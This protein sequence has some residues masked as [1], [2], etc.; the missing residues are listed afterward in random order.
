MNWIVPYSTTWTWL[1]QGS[2]NELP[3]KISA[4]A[5]S[6]G[7]EH[8]CAVVDDE[9]EVALAVGLPHGALGEREEL[10]AQVDERHSAHPAA[11][12]QLEEAP[13]ERQRLVERADLDGDVIDP[14][15]ASHCVA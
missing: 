3:P 14:D 10:V 4:P 12:L 6:G 7:R 9:P 11:E 15:R 1:P 8:G 5:S 13:V 2:R